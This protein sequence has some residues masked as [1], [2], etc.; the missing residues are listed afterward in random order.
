MKQF[1]PAL[2]AKFL[3]N[4][5]VTH[6]RLLRRVR[7]EGLPAPSAEGS[8]LARSQFAPTRRG[9][10]RPRPPKSV[11]VLIV[12]KSQKLVHQPRSFAPKQ[13]QPLTVAIRPRRAS[14]CGA[15]HL[16]PP[17]RTTAQE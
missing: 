13:P 14:S 16:L 1:P 3:P 9:H 17:H 11:S 2:S 6:L 4:L 8:S 12:A 7:S 10:F 15:R 5:G